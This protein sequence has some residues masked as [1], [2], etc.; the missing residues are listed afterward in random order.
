MVLCVRHILAGTHATE[1]QPS[2]IHD[3]E[4]S[5]VSADASD[6]GLMT[7][8]AVPKNDYPRVQRSPEQPRS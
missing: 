1:E 2:A 5:M 3:R 8:S 7:R 6:T 4:A